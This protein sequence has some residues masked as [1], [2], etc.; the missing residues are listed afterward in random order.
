MNHSAHVEQIQLLRTMIRWDG[1]QFGLQ[2]LNSLSQHRYTGLFLFNG[3]TLINTFIYDRQ[4]AV[5]NLFPEKPANHSYCLS[6]KHSGQ[7]FQVDNAALDQRVK[8]HPNRDKVRSYCGVPLRDHDGNIFGTLCHF[9]PDPC[10]SEN[11]EILLMQ[12]FAA[13][14]LESERL[15]EI[16]WR[17]PKVS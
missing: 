8:D 1:I 15:G 12:S 13:V 14:L 4:S 5:Q 11:D 9:S 10:H 7:P 2:Y 3:D 16:G 17:S 6:V